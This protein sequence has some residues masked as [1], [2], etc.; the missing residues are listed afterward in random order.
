MSLYVLQ[1][2][3]A[4]YVFQLCAEGPADSEESEDGVS[5][6]R[7]YELPACEFHGL[8]DSLIYDEAV[9]Q[10]LVTYAATALFFSDRQVDQQLISF[11]RT[12]L[13]H[14]PA[15]TGKTSL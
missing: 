7:E 10:R 9:K 1:V 12:V 14:G 4:I 8:W 15:G 6:Y 11:N 2:E 13:L 5:A 3:F